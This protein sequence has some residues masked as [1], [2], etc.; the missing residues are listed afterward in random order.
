M[1]VW[2]P[3]WRGNRVLVLSGGKYDSYCP[4]RGRLEGERQGKQI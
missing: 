4:N 3:I 2:E 1:K